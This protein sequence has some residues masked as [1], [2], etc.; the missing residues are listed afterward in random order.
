MLDRISTLDPMA[1]VLPILVILALTIYCTVEVAQAV[2]WSVRF[3]PKWLWAFIV[4]CLPVIGPVAWLIWGRP[5]VQ[6]SRP[7]DIPPDDDEDFLSRL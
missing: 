6:A 1:R 3:A 7:R 4:I 2:S 5:R